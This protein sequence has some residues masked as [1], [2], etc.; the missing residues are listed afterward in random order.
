M[1]EGLELPGNHSGFP[2]LPL[3]SD[4]TGPL[5]EVHLSIFLPGSLIKQLSLIA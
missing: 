2:P 5:F 4:L 3:Y 1:P